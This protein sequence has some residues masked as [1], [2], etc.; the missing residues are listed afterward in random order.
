M[1]SEDGSKLKNTTQN[2]ESVLGG[3]EKDVSEQL[4]QDVYKRQDKRMVLL[5]DGRVHPVI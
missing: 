5:S 3:E 4:A 1:E 2:L